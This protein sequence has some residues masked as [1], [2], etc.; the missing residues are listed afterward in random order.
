MIRTIYKVMIGTEPSVSLSTTSWPLELLKEIQDEEDLRRI[1][2]DE[3]EK[4]TRLVYRT[5]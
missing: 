3:N 1:F 5:K 2:K 4:E